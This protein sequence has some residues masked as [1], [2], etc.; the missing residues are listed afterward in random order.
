M[1]AIGDI[2]RFPS[3]RQ[4]VSYLGL[5]PRVRQ[6]GNHPARYGR[7]SKAGASETR[8]MFG[9]LSQWGLRIPLRVLRA[10]DAMAMLER[11]GLPEVWRRSVAEAL[12]VIDILDAP[13]IA[14][15]EAE[16][17]PLARADQRVR[18]LTTILGVGEHLALMIAAEIG[19]EPGFHP[20]QTDRL[21]RLGGCSRRTHTPLDHAD[22]RLLRA[23]ARLQK[24]RGK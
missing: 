17:R 20:A 9:A 12:A 18:L 19:D 22:Q 10:G 1:A 2:R 4:L 7:I 16:L 15:L 6:S 21:D 13:R 3:A 11:R 24:R 14:P 23:L 8:H 5:D